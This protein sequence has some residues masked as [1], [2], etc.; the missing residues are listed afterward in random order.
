MHVNHL[1]I[2]FIVRVL[3]ESESIL[4]PGCDFRSNCPPGTTFSKCPASGQFPHLLRRMSLLS[5]S[6][7]A[8]RHCG[9]ACAAATTPACGTDES[10]LELAWIWALARS[11][12]CT[13]DPV[14]RFISANAEDF[15]AM[16]PAQ[17][18]S[19]LGLLARV[20]LA[21]KRAYEVTSWRYF[22]SHCCPQSRKRR[23]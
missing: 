12:R 6:T 1:C 15:T 10:L 11:R 5:Q 20:V 23:R 16:W 17:K 19:H 9:M 2:C 4:C 21:S 7:S 3:E 22:R 8:N 14:G 18:S 13:I